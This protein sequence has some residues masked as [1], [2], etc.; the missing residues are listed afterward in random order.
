M[1]IEKD[2]LTLEVPD[3]D[4]LDLVARMEKAVKKSQSY[5]ELMAKHSCKTPEDLAIHMFVRQYRFNCYAKQKGWEIPHP[6]VKKL[7]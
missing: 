5:R 6:Q 1:K 3:A 7:G 4:Y 2:N